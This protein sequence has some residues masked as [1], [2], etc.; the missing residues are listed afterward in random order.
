MTENEKEVENLIYF[1]LKKLHEQGRDDLAEE[2]CEH[3]DIVQE[4]EDDN[5]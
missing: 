5:F 3:F 4:V 2:W 1:V